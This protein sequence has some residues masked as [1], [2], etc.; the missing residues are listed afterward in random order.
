M[1]LTGYAA[2]DPTYANELRTVIQKDILQ[3]INS[4]QPHPYRIDDHQQPSAIDNEQHP[5]AI[6]NQQQPFAI[7]NKQQPFAI[8]NQQQSSTIDDW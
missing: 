4:T 7:D 2:N 6:D 5:S 3:I 1:A 8:D